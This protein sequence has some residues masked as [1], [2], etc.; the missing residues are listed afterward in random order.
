MG[1]PWPDHRAPVILLAKL[2]LYSSK[3]GS[4]RRRC[5]IAFAGA[6]IALAVSAS[7]TMAANQTVTVGQTIN[8]FTPANVSITAGDT[9]T[10]NNIAGFHNVHL[11]N[12]SFDQP[13]SPANAP[14][15]VANTFNT[16]GTYRYYCEIHGGPNGAGMS[17]TVAVKAP[18]Q[19][20]LTAS[21][22]NVSLV[23]LFKQAGTPGNPT[24]AS[25]AAPFS[26]GS[27]TPPATTA[28]AHVGTA[29]AGSAQM[30]VTPGDVNTAAD[31][32][33]VSFTANATDV[34]ATSPTGPDYNPNPSGPDLTLVT[35]FRISDLSNGGAATDQG[36]LTDLDFAIPVDCATTAGGAGSNCSASTT[37]DAVSPGMIKEGAAPSCRHSGFASS[38]PGPTTC[39][40]TG[41]T[42][43]SS[44]RGSCAPLEQGRN[45]ASEI[46]GA[47]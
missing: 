10:W 29:G 38:T 43:S 17:G 47:L 16:T 30:A 35:K 40:A 22:L 8:T 42:G 34:R 3:L 14:W 1:P 44:S 15:T 28:V 2:R 9:V 31:E 26:V 18:Y 12:N 23:P 19:T 45:F 6:M 13:A 33:N 7:P 5:L 39:V 41:T 4:V 25:H 46:T 32:A 21:P 27:S 11:D 20:P 24:N 36:T 37:A